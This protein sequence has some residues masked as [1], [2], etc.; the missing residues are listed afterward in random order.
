MFEAGGHRDDFNL[1]YDELLVVMKAVVGSMDLWTRYVALKPETRGMA[2]AQTRKRKQ[3]D[4]LTTAYAKLIT[5]KV[6][7]KDRK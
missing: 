3:L 2:G 4:V 6:M 1:T 5:Q 7:H